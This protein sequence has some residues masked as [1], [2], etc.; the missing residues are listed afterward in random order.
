[1]EDKT[2]LTNNPPPKKN[3][4]LRARA[5]CGCLSGGGG[6]LRLKRGQKAN[7]TKDKQDKRPTRPTRQ[8]N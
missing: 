4:G 5:F 2:R 3:Q 8:N 1:M 7:K 6:S